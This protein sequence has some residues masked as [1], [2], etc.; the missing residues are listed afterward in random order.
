MFPHVYAYG[1][2]SII[3]KLDSVVTEYPSTTEEA[4]QPHKA[5]D[6]MAAFADPEVEAIFATIGGDNQKDLIPLLKPGV[7]TANP[8]PFFGYSD[9]THFHNYLWKLGVPSYYGGSVMTQ[10]AMPGKTDEYTMKSVR[11]GLKNEKNIILK[12]ASTFA[13][14]DANWN[15]EKFYFRQKRYLPAPTVEWDGTETVNGIAWGGCLE[16]LCEITEFPDAEKM[17]G[18]VLIIETS[19]E[20]P[21][22][23]KV[24][25][26]LKTLEKHKI[27][28]QA[29]AVLVGIPK[30]ESRMAETSD[31][32]KTTYRNAQHDIIKKTIRAY[33]S[34]APIVLNLN[35]GH[36]DPQAIIPLGRPILVDSY[37]KLVVLNYEKVI[38]PPK[39]KPEAAVVTDEE[40]AYEEE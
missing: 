21:T 3:E 38:A 13:E 36:T 17:K 28:S 9:N 19:E 15:D 27:L 7:F 6:L 12:H 22:A 33:N 35:F 31:G 16:S 5:K 24:Q 10:F 40:T 8:K 18:I 30:A 39:P 25:K 37:S 29:A 1:L 4:D 23:P 11:S 34:H 26:M 2:R 32:E 20:M 14:G